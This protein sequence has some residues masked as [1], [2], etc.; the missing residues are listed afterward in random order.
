MAHSPSVRPSASVRPHDFHSVLSEDGDRGRERDL[1]RDT[2]HFPAILL[3]ERF[4][5]FLIR[6]RR[7]CLSFARWVWSVLCLCKM[8]M[9]QLKS[10]FDYRRGMWKKT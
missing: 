3:R 6:Q 1:D 8:V 2:A 4:F 5:P 10:E 7:R 9:L